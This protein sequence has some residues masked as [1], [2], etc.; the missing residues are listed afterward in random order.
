LEAARRISD[1]LFQHGDIDALVEAALRAALEEV[2]AEAGSILL[3]DPDAKHLVFHYS[4]GDRPV[5]RGT[6]IPWDQGIAGRV[7]Q[8]G[9]PA[10]INN[11]KQASGHYAGIDQATGFVTRDMI[12]LPLKRWKGDPLGVINVL[13]K[14][15]GTLNEHDLALLSIVSAFAAL[16]IQ[17]ARLFEEA[18]L[19]EVVHLLGDIGH[20]LKNLL[21]PVV[22]GTWLLKSELDDIFSQ[23]P[24]SD[25]EKKHARRTICEETLKMLDSASARIVGFLGGRLPVKL[26]DE[27]QSLLGEVKHGATLLKE[28]LAD[29]LRAPEPFDED[30]A[31][32][33]QAACEEALAMIQRTSERIHDR[34]K[35]IADCVKGLSAPPQFA[36][37]PLGAVVGEVFGTLGVLAQEKQITLTTKGLDQLPPIFADERRLYN[38]FYNLVNNAIPE[39]PNGG[40]IT[41]TGGLDDHGELVHVSVADTGRGMP[42]E[43]RERLFSPRAIS[44]KRCG[45]G[46]GTKI[47]KDVIDVH[48]GRISVESEVGVGT[49]FHLHLP[50]DPRKFAAAKT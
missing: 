12:T 18:K 31:N 37:C 15:E 8:S 14:R 22:S 17:Q 27:V 38:A 48:H 39:V 19:A 7:F 10:I 41:V 29:A 2:G 36:A 9:E 33:T 44:T 49:V 40:A 5:A 30:M 11:V 13:N 46:L 50:V 16:A 23:W 24:S 6:A 4:L 1:T 45:T 3:A 21:Q 26:N 47:V 28:C 32:A 43:V 20:D 35:E 25:P 34:V 42:P